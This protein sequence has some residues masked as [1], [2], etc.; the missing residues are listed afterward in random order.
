MDFSLIVLVVIVAAL[1]FDFTNGFHDTANAMATSIATGALKPRIAVAV[2]AVLN[3]VGAFLSVEVAKTISGGIVDDT[4]VTPVIIFA[5]LVGAIVWNLVTWLIGLPSSSSHALFG[6]LIGATWIASGSDAVHFG[7]V[8]EKVLIPA[9]ASPIVA[10][11]VATLG[12]FLVYRITARAKQDTVGRTFKAGQIASASL[13]SLA[14]GTN[15]A[16][17]TMGVITLTLIA[18]RLARAELGPAG[19]GDPD[20]GHRDRARH[21]PRWLADHPDDGQEAHRNPDAA[22]F[23]GRDERRGGHPDLGAPRLRAVHHARLLGR[24][25]RLRPRPQAR[26]GPLGRRGQDGARLGA[27]AARRR[28]RRRARRRDLDARRPGAPS[29]SAWP[30]SSSRLGIYLASRRNPVNANSVT[31][32][33]PVTQPA[34]A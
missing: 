2:S 16:Q 25:H 13:V 1:A 7:K 3:L 31:E 27:D 14:H 5:G 8:V 26:R 15:D 11:I 30:G 12:T 18:V 32:P 28:D 23:R 17:K 10:G 33:E 19:L 6:G 29:W 20:R 24:H 9:L 22:G 34:N 21:L 4:K